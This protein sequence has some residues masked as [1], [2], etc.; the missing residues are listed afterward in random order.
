MGLAL[1]T[2][3]AMEKKTVLRERISRV[4]LSAMERTANASPVMKQKQRT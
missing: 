3:R 2:S 1:S 4:G